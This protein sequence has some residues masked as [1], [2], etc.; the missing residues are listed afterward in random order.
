MGICGHEKSIDGIAIMLIIIRVLMNAVAYRLFGST[1][2]V[3]P[4]HVEEVYIFQLILFSHIRFGEP[5]DA[6]SCVL[7]DFYL[8][9]QPHKTA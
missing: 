4:M 5:Q 2:S 7:F 1:I 6:Q 9:G 8:F 3:L